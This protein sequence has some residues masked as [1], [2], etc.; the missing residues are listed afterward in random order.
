MSRDMFR[1][2]CWCTQ[3]R[4]RTPSHLL[5]TI[6]HT[7]EPEKGVN[8]FTR[9]PSNSHSTYFD[10]PTGTK[11]GGILSPDFFSLYIDE[12][13]ELLKNAKIGC[14]VLSMFIGCILFADDLTLLSP[15]RRGMQLLIDICAKFCRLNCLD[16]NVSKTKS[17]VFGSLS[18]SDCKNLQLNNDSIEFVKDW[19][20]LGTTI[21]SGKEF[22]FSARADL[23]SFYKAFNSINNVLDSDEI[24]LMKL[25][26][27]NC[28]SIFS[29]A[30]S[31][32]K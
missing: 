6:V 12:L 2:S 3:R 21:V 22:S 32:K 19:K 15:S 30:C 27:T 23:H 11:Q 7:L 18:V 17:M 24:V 4:F 26:Y 9:T 25:L 10:I 16:I 14:H 29:Y 8:S 13:V 20:Y 1:G 28:V 5:K 31:V